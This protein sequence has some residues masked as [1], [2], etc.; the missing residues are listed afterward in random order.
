MI[1]KDVAEDIDMDISIQIILNKNSS[2]YD[3]LNKLKEKNKNIFIYPFSDSV[4]QIMESCDIAIGALGTTTWERCFLGIPC[5]VYSTHI[6]QMY[7]LNYL[8]SLDIV[9]DI[10]EWTRWVDIGY[11]TWS[12]T[13]M[14]YFLYFKENKFRT[15]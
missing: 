12:I 5:L 8:K 2:Y 11:L 3:K 10:F 13:V 15:L 4:H 14:I 6:N 7:F 1:L 9:F